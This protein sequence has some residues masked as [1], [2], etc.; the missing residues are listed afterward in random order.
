MA[1]Q[2]VTRGGG[3][4]R[5]CY[6]YPRPAFAVDMVVLAVRDPELE[7][8]LIRRRDPPYRGRWALPGGFVEVRDDGDQGEDLD[9]AAARELQ[10]ETGLRPR[11]VWLQQFHTFGRP[12]RDP[13]GRVISVGYFALV[14]P[15]L[16]P[17]AGDDAIAAQWLPLSR[18]RTLSLA[19]DHAQMLE[20]ALRVIR[21]RAADELPLVARLVPREFTKLE[22][23]RALELVGGQRLDQSNFNKRFNRMIDEG[24]IVRLDGVRAR[25]R[26]GRPA[27]LHRFAGSP[28]GGRARRTRPRTPG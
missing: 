6:D 4:P 23:R 28:R 3:K 8:L 27:E 24:A 20:V 21:Q 15:H 10:E 17:Q 19:F 25:S 11:E 18:V 13:R 16:S 7:L 22:L 5:F 14:P 26:P 12:G 2:P 9:D 1:R